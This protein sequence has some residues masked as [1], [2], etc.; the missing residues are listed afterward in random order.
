[1]SELLTPLNA[2]P[3]ERCFTSSSSRSTYVWINGEPLIT[4]FHRCPRIAIRPNF[5]LLTL[6]RWSFIFARTRRRG[7]W[8]NLSRYR[9]WGE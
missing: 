6:W 9:R 3:T 4:K 1:M 2:T 8:W 5:I 7:V